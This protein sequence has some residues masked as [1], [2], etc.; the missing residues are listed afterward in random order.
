MLPL[1]IEGSHNR[2][3]VTEC[4]ATH[5]RDDSILG[6]YQMSVSQVMRCRQGSNGRMPCSPRWRLLPYKSTFS[7]APRDA[8]N[9]ARS[10][11]HDGPKSL[12]CSPSVRRSMS[13]WSAGRSSSSPAS[14]SA[15]RPSPRCERRERNGRGLASASAPRLPRPTPPRDS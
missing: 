8:I 14:P 13:A 1:C 3:D 4:P 11:E 15:L 6:V 12:C 10:V 2:R 7:T 9:C 5:V